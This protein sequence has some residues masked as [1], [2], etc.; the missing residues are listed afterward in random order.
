[1]TGRLGIFPHKS[2]KLKHDHCFWLL[3]N[4][5]EMRFN[6]TRRFGSI[7]IAGS[8]NELEKLFIHFGPDPFSE[9][10]NAEYLLMRAEGRK[11]AVK[12]FI[13][14]N[15][16]VPG[17]GNIYASETLYAAGI[18]PARNIASLTFEEWHDIVRQSRRILK[19][20]IKSGGTTISDYVNSN[21]EKGYFQVGLLVYGQN[22]KP[23]KKCGH[24]IEKS[25]ISG[26]GSFFCPVCQK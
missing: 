19:K 20:A 15:R 3:D 8:E 23:C 11:V 10:F 16:I 14:D 13:M 26:R 5:M 4:N 25:V 7:Q 22:G 21:G 1:M 9:T 2:P 12:N 6:D 18:H 17:I 24:H